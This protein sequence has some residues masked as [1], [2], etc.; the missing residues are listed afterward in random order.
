MTIA[1]YPGSF[2]PITNGHLD[3]V[4]RASRLFDTV[5]LAVFDRPNKNLLFSTRERITMVKEAIADL[6]RIKV[7]TYSEL[8]IEYVR[9]V[10][11]SV[12]VRGLRDPRDFDH[13]FQM[14]QINNKLAPEI[15]VVLFMAGHAY[16]FFSSSTVREIASLGGDVSWL[17][18]PH[19]VSA[20]KRAYAAPA[21]NS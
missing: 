2:D 12:I 1:V 8:T 21:V 18:P 15:D 6:P 7:D 13:E 14:A 3:I 5:I 16:T 17:V 11:A 9:Q 19:V 10:G 20:L 4:T